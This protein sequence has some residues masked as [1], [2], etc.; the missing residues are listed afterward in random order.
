MSGH[1]VKQ[2][3]LTL[4]SPDPALFVMIFLAM[5]SFQPVALEEEVAFWTHLILDEQRRF[6]GWRQGL[7]GNVGRND[8]AI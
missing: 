1:Q 4:R 6:V 3:D 5:S 7:S 2:H 8:L